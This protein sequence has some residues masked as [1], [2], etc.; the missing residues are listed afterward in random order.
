MKYFI[1]V[2]LFGCQAVNTQEVS[3]EQM[4]ELE[5]EKLMKGVQMTNQ[6]SSQ[7]QQQAAEKEVQIVS[8]AVSTIVD[9]KQEV[10]KLKTELNEVKAKLDSVNNIDNSKPFSIKGA[11]S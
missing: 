5:F 4:K 10:K 2:F 11:G 9:L 3:K 6:L 1:I 8:K 7:A